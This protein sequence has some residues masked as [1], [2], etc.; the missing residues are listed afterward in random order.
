MAEKTWAIKCYRRRKDA[1]T[2]WIL[3]EAQKKLGFNPVI[4]IRIRLAST[5][6]THIAGK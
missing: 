2:D 5:C 3:E 1:L 4:G 6:T